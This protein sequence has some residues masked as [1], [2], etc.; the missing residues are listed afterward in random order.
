MYTNSEGL[1]KKNVCVLIVGKKK[2]TQT[3]Q[4]GDNCVEICLLILT[5]SILMVALLMYAM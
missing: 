2:K 4:Y 3:E 5:A 1:K